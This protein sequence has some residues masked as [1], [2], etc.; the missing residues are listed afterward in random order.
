MR[1]LDVKFMYGE[2]GDRRL[3]GVRSL[4][5]HPDGRLLACAGM[6]SLAGLGD[7]IGMSTVALLD[8]HTGPLHARWVPHLEIGRIES[9]AQIKLPQSAWGAICIPTAGICCW[10]ITIAR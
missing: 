7:G 3:S 6:S 1:E 5:F 4:V 10:L 2:Q 9:C 8:W